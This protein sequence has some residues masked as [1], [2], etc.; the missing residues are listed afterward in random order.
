MGYGRKGYQYVN[1][2]S[3]FNK[4]NMIGHIECLAKIQDKASNIIINF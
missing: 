4:H 2:W 1:N 3:F